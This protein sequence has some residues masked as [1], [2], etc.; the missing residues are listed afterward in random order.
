[1][2]HYQQRSGKDDT[3]VTMVLS[4]LTL[5]QLSVNQTI[6]RVS[7]RGFAVE[8][9]KTAKSRRTIALAPSLCT[10]FRKRRERQIQERL[11]LGL[12]LRDSDLVF[13]RLDGK[14]LDPD[15][16]THAFKKIVRKAGMPHVRFHDLRHTHAS[17]MLKLGVHPKI[18][19]ERLGH[20]SIGITLDTY[21]HV[22]PGL[23]EA[24]A[25]RFEEDLLDARATQ[26]VKG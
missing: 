22:M 7:S 6:Q 25:R 13:A 24:A 21:S 2:K 26:L 8:A 20:S 4:L 23:Q 18:V 5:A 12:T 19:S 10:L 11:L 3:S 1:M 14:P 17:L 15:T 9:P 16:V